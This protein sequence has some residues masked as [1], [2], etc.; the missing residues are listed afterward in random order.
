M[1]EYR[2]WF[3]VDGYEEIELPV[4]PQE[5]TI[6][7]PG[8]S[9]NYDVEGIGEIVIPRIPKLATITFESFFPREMVWQTVVN[10]ESW[11][12]PEWYVTF[13]RNIQKSRQPFELTIVRGY[14]SVKEYDSVGGVTVNKTD[15]FD[16]VLD[17]A[18][19]LDF[20]ITDKGGEPG[21]V[22]YSM[23]VSEY[24]DASPKSMAELA[25]EEVDESGN[26]LSQKMVMVVNR[27]PQTGVIAVG[28][29]VQVNGEVHETPES[30]DIDWAKAQTKAN[31]L[32]SVVSRVLPPEVSSEV[33]SVYIDSLGWVD[34]GSCKLAESTGTMNGVNRL[35]TD[36]YD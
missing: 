1:S 23:A 31:Q 19:I 7:Y 20:S 21:D 5:V 35:L 26:V 36:N 27:P 3:K 4:N 15:Y 9:T 25:E 10:S 14:D 12:P 11:Y 24:R 22:Y 18:V 30:S 2:I 34:K 29:T 32:D 16:T 6:T 28:R 13:F 33:H 8:N 17:K